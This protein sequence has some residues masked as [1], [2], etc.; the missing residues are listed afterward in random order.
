MAEPVSFL[1]A[2]A[3]TSFLAERVIIQCFT[4]VGSGTV[5]LFLQENKAVDTI[6]NSIAI[7]VLGFNIVGIISTGY[8]KSSS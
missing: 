2:G 8:A 4:T 7:L 1:P 5:S 3:G 6:N